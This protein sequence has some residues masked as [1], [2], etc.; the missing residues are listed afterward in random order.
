MPEWNVP[1][2]TALRALGSGGFGEVVLARHDGSGVPGAI[3]YLRRGL[4]SDTEF[5]T[6]FRAEAAVLASLEDV[7]VVRLY[8]DVESA[9]GAAIVIA[10]GD[11]GHRARSAPGGAG[12]AGPGA[13]AAAAA[14]D[15]RDGQEPPAPASRRDPPGRRARYDRVRRVRPGLARARPVA[16]GRGGSAARD[17][18]AVR[19]AARGAGHRDLPDPPVP[20]VQPGPDGRHGGRRARRPG[21]RPRPR[22]PRPRPPRPR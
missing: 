2:Y 20:A 3:Q 21:R 10:L 17:A 13:R 15:G 11:G 16:P 6:M 8:A 5:A 14:G 22:R 18:V 4:L 19:H 7:Y 12:A 1:G 9:W